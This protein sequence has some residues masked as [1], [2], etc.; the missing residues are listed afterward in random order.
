MLIPANTKIGATEIVPEKL[1]KVAI[2]IAPEQLIKGTNVPK[3]LLC[4]VVKFS[5]Q[6]VSVK[7][8]K[9]NS[10][11]CS[12]RTSCWKIDL[13]FNQNMKIKHKIWKKNFDWPMK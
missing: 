8:N 1:I 13:T 2:E 9:L 11:T 5:A 12:K 7:N 4:Q 10:R 3:R 6:K